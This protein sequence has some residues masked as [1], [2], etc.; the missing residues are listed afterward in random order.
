MPFALAYAGMADS[1]SLTASAI[2]PA[3]RFPKARAAAL[4]ALELDE[5]LA[6]AHNALAFITYKADWQWVVSEREFKRALE[7]DPNYVLSHQWFGEFLSIIGRH[8]AGIAELRRAR[9]LDP[10]SV[11]VLVDLGIPMGLVIAS[12]HEKRDEYRKML[13][14]AGAPERPRATRR[15]PF[16]RF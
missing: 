1:Y 3:E 7:L 14:A 4:K 11:A 16:I 2:P 5:T 6:E 15:K 12:I 10:Y 8:D 13:V 9:E